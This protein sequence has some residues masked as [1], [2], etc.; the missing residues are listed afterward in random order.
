VKWNGFCQV[1]RTVFPVRNWI[2]ICGV[3]QIF[4]YRMRIVTMRTFLLFLMVFMGNPALANGPEEWE[5]FGIS[6]SGEKVHLT[7]GGFEL[8]QANGGAATYRDPTRSIYGYCQPS[9]SATEGE[10]FLQCSQRLSGKT[11]LIFKKDANGKTSAYYRKAKAIYQRQF[12]DKD[13]HR[14]FGGYYRCIEGCNRQV[15]E[16]LV[17]INYGD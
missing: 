15:A 16:L 5:L 10:Y 2:S 1:F 13:R 4:T 6:E 14:T 17:E 11:H 8:E 12:K 3:S 9:A 7:Y